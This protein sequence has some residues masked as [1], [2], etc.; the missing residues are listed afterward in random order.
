MDNFEVIAA[1]ET[2]FS[3][4][5]LKES[6]S[7]DENTGEFR[8]INKKSKRH[9]GKLAGT[10]MK[11]GYIRLGARIGGKL[12]YFLAHRVAWAFCHDS[13]PARFIDHKDRVKSNN[14]LCNLRDVDRSVNAYNYSRRGKNKTGYRGVFVDRRWT[15]E[16]Y[17]ASYG[18]KHLGSFSTAEDARDCYRAYV[19]QIHDE[20]IKD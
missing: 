13:W 2:V 18:K 3:L 1:K 16:R 8:S 6:F 14:R 19:D 15:N 5:V 4:G 10:S 12:T 7:Y 17:N 9:F 11:S 20:I